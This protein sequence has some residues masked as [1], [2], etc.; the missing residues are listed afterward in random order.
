MMIRMCSESLKHGYFQLDPAST[1]AQAT[2]SSRADLNENSQ[3]SRKS[4]EK[5]E[6]RRGE[7]IVV[8]PN[9]VSASMNFEP[10]F[11]GK[12]GL[13]VSLSPQHSKAS[14]QHSKASP[15][16]QPKSISKMPRAVLTHTEDEV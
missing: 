12:S 1:N 5:K 11:P 15:P 2:H 7:K 14:P 3:S 9:A 16:P 4:D 8:G 10:P 6:R 13:P